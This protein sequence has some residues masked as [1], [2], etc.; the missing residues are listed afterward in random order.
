MEQKAF[1]SN[2][3]LI[4]SDLK[5][6]YQ[7]EKQFKNLIKNYVDV[8]LAKNEKE[9]QNSFLKLNIS[10]NSFLQLAK[11]EPYANKFHE[12]YLKEITEGYIVRA[13]LAQKDKETK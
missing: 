3:K 10:K 5:L 8:N 11:Q 2:A 1:L 6:I 13:Y 9:Y 7:A 4:L 12:Y